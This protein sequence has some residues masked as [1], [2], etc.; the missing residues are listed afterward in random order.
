MPGRKQAAAQP[1][2]QDRVQPARNRARNAGRRPLPAHGFLIALTW[3]SGCAV[4][5]R[6]AAEVFQTFCHT[7]KL[8]ADLSGN[9]PDAGRRFGNQFFS[10][11]GGI[12]RDRERPAG[13]I[14]LHLVPAF[15][16]E[17]C[18]LRLGFDPFG[19]NRNF[20]TPAEPDNRLDDGD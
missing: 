20:E 14:A 6:P 19:Q 16:R 1:H 11:D 10:D 12:V 8:S 9:R 4:A 5:R 3:R 18:V 7:C 13:Q 17:E 2:L 15:P